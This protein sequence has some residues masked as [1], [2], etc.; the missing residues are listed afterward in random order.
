VEAGHRL[1]GAPVDMRH[2]LLASIVLLI[3]MGVDV[4]RARMLNRAAREHGSQALEADAL[5]FSTDVL[6]SAA[7]LLGVGLAWATHALGV[8][9]LARADAIAAI[10]IALL[11]LGLSWRL[12]LRTVRVLTDEVPPELGM[13]IAQAVRSVHGVHEPLR[14]RARQSGDRTFVDIIAHVR[15]D[16]HVH[17]SHALADKIEE[18]VRACVRNVDVVVHLEPTGKHRSTH[19]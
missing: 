19:D 14:I 18:A 4:S 7:A 13:Q 10:A 3:S 16:M 2:P 9:W 17:T 11:T 12:G 5:H 8:A 6:S 15:R 1:Q